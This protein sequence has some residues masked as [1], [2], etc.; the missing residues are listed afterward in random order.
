MPKY[1]F[2]E[3]KVTTITLDDCECE[4]VSP[5]PCEECDKKAWDAYDKGEGSVQTFGPD[6]EVA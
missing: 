4:Q 2:T 5:E 1:K 6:W 3:Q